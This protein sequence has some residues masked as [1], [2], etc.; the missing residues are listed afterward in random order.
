[1]LFYIFDCPLP[2]SLKSGNG[3]PDSAAVINQLSTPENKLLIKR[4]LIK[5]ADVSNPTRP[6][7]MCKEWAK[8]IAN[9]YCSQVKIIKIIQNYNSNFITVNCKENCIKWSHKVQDK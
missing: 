2:L 4:M 1:M 8:R 9:E 3:S 6:L 5:C 7:V